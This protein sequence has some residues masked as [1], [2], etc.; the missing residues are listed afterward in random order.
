MKTGDAVGL[1]FFLS[2]GGQ[3]V[4]AQ[5]A[6]GAPADPA[7]ESTARSLEEV[8]V[9]AQKRE[10]SI[11][12]VPMSISALSADDLRK[13]GVYG[14]GDL[15][16]V[17]PG[18]HYTASAYSTPIYAIR[19]IGFNESSLGAKPNVSVYVDEIPLPFPIVTA[20]ASMDLQRVEV[21]KG[22]QGTLFGQNSTG[23]AINYIAA[24]PTD[25]LETGVSAEF[26]RF[27]T[28]TLDG[29][30]SGPLADTV[31]GRIAI[32]SELG[33]EWQ[34]SHTSDRE[35]G[36]RRK[37]AAR[38]L[39]AWEPSERLKTQLMLNGYIDRSDEQASQFIA[40]TPLRQP[41]VFA[42]LIDTYP[43]APQ[44]ARAAD[45]GPGEH[46]R[47]DNRFYQAAL[48]VDYSLSDE[49]TLTSISAYS[50]YT[51]DRIQDPDGMSLHNI[52]YH[53]D[54]DIDSISEELRLAGEIG[55]STRW[56]VGANY[57]RDNV[58]QRDD[59]N[60]TYN[61]NAYALGAPPFFT[62]F[63][64]SDQ[65]FDTRAAFANL[66]F[67]LTPTV[68]AHAAARYTQADLDF[69][70]CTG[71]AGDGTLSAAWNRVFGTAVAPGECV[72]LT[73]TFQ[74]GLVNKELDETNVSWRGGLDWHPTSDLLV[75]AN[76]SKGYKSG[77]FPILSA[78]TASQLNPVTQE[79]VL[80]Y[81]LGFK[82]TSSERT[83]QLNG[84][85]FYYDYKDKQVRGRVV[86]PVFGALEALVNVPKSKVQGAELQLNW[87]AMEGL[88]AN[89]GVT[90]IDSEIE[91]FQNFDP[92][93]RP[94]NFDGE[95]FPL[96]PGWQ[97]FADV[98]YEWP[99]ND[100]LRAFVGANVSHQS[101]TYGAMGELELLKIDAYTL[102][103]LR[104][105]AET[106]DGRWRFTIWGRNV[107]DEYYWTLAEH[108][109]DTTVRFAA[110]PATY[111]ISV[112]LRYR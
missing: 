92:Y 101:S 40:A 1:V 90:Y 70:G 81:E 29:Y 91:D 2:L 25:S 96:T 49:M 15:M 62:Y 27:N 109:S 44:D 38:A 16:K 97:G 99:L 52:E 33:D 75:Y 100:S 89:V 41:N 74:T 108:V 50:A 32:Q 26:G 73:P 87:L 48:R 39:L 110:M 95:S 54:A 69:A 77:S 21:L 8:V 104:A 11:N 17:V 5:V 76:V 34:E 84:A 13:Q 59:G 64:F 47:R 53:T 31:Q 23:G 35:L 105:G 93:G 63:N 18:F 14:V 88:T 58:E 22:P 66:D 4:N 103:D 94:A 56:I 7:T 24:K 36:K 6:T 67:D 12:D 80:A 86:V 43:I 9:T 10:E 60:I 19:G 71:D 106:Q 79:S 85:A 98:Q 112:A 68:T 78:S 55:A 111:G 37:N 45:W 46:Y 72:T 102:L 30:L 3:A 51:Q 82:L 20:G 61:N 57:A 42:P 65:R 28:T 83:L 107:T